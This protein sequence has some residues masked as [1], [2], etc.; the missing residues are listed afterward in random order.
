MPTVVTVSHFTCT[1]RCSDRAAVQRRSASAACHVQHAVRSIPSQNAQAAAT[2]GGVGSGCDGRPQQA[3]GGRRPHRQ[4]LPQLAVVDRQLRGVRRGEVVLRRLH[5]DVHL[6]P[7]R[8]RRGACT[9]RT[10]AVHTW[11]RVG[12][13]S[14]ADERSYAHITCSTRGGSGSASCLAALARCGLQRAAATSQ[15]HPPAGGCSRSCTALACRACS[16]SPSQNRRA[17]GWLWTAVSRG[18]PPAL[19]IP[20]SVPPPQLTLRLDNTT[21]WSRQPPR[22]P[23]FEL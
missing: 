14:A 7:A 16:P 11:C 9:S 4:P 17:Q 12:Y 13:W 23:T 8:R 20:R 18:P 5:A 2:Y 15:R 10:W 19:Q 1:R 6:L 21:G 22:L 3:P